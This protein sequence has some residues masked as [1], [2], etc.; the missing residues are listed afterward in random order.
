[1]AGVLVDFPI[2]ESKTKDSTRPVG[3]L[4]VENGNCWWRSSIVKQ[5][6]HYFALRGV[7]HR[8][9]NLYIVVFAIQVP[10]LLREV[11]SGANGFNV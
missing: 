8:R 2:V 3:L 7:S 1:L 11:S 10:F 9:P 5:S 4:K 6:E